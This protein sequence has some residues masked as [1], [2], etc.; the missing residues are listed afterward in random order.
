M[1]KVKKVTKSKNRKT[2]K[3]IK[4]KSLKNDKKIIKN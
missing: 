1:Q 4:L 2:E 3:V